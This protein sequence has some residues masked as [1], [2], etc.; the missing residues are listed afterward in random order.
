[1]E[2][3]G[4][5]PDPPKPQ[6][7]PSLA[8]LLRQSQLLQE[9]LGPSA[10]TESPIS[11]ALRALANLGA[12][13]SPVPPPPPTI[14]DRWFKDQT[15]YIDGYVF[16]RC[17][18]DRCNLVT[19]FATFIFRQSFISPDCR[20]FFKGPSLKIA[21]LLMHQLNMSSRVEKYVGEGGIFATIN[22]DGTFTLE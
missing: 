18:F 20:I 7:Q 11:A 16:E 10:E 13:G 22:F 1:M 6:S 8:D 19:E 17:R 21:R 3:D 4:V 12:S 15:V 14:C 2:V 9:T 5:S